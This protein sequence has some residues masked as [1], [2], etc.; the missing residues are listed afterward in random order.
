MK[1]KFNC[2][3]CGKEKEIY[4]LVYDK[5]KHHFCSKKCYG[6]FKTGETVF[7]LQCSECNKK[8]TRASSR[9][10]YNSIN[11]TYCSVPCCRTHKTKLAIVKLERK[12]KELHETLKKTR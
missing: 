12:L 9:Y 6:I 10:V 7:E 1:V 3:Q 5:A 8:F 2:E 11:Y 4:S